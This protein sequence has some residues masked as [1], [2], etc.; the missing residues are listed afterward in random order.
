MIIIFLLLLHCSVGCFQS[1]HVPVL[2]SFSCDSDHPE[3]YIL[4][5]TEGY[6]SGQP[7]FSAKGLCIFLLVSDMTRSCSS[8]IF[9]SDKWYPFLELTTLEKYFEAIVGKYHCRI[10]P[11]STPLPAHIRTLFTYNFDF[12]SFVKYSTIDHST[13]T[14]TAFIIT[15]NKREFLQSFSKKKR[16]NCYIKWYSMIKESLGTKL[17]NFLEEWDYFP[18]MFNFGYPCFLSL[19]VSSRLQTHQSQRGSRNTDP[20]SK[21]APKAQACRRFREMLLILTP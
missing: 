8:D 5:I 10:V 9:A 13:T 20:F 17:T 21:R 16:R 18:I 11:L 12:R 2:C 3:I 19:P 4:Q 14:T 6:I 1:V 15:S 7:C